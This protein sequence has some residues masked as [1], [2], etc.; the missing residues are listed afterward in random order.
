MALMKRRYNKSD[1]TSKELVFQTRHL[2][3]DLHAKLHIVKAARNAKRPKT[4]PPVTI[5]QVL[6]EALERGL[7]AIN[8]E[9]GAPW[10]VAS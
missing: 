10:T 2:R 3:R 4:S 7:T 5:D 9:E 1:P 6:N 8:A